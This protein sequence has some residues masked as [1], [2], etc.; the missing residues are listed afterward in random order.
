MHRRLFMVLLCLLAAV[1]AACTATADDVQPIIKLRSLP[2]ATVA[3]EPMASVRGVVTWRQGPNFIMQDGAAAIFINLYES[4]RRGLT[5][6]RVPAPTVIPGAKLEVAGRLAAGGFAPILLPTEIRVL[7][8]AAM[9]DPHRTTPRRFFSGADDCLLVEVKGIVRAVQE[10]TAALELSMAVDGQRF[11]VHVDKEAVPGRYGNL[12]DAEVQVAG[13]ALARFNTRGELTMPSLAVGMGGWI[14][15]VAP[16]RQ[17]PF[18]SPVVPLRH[19]AGYRAE[20]RDGHMVRIQGTVNHAVPAMELFLQDGATGV[21]VATASPEVFTPG[22]RVEAAGFIETS[23]RVASLSHA[24]VRRIASGTPPRP[25]AITP[26]EIRAKNLFAA[27]AFTMAEPGDY[28]GCLVTFPATLLEKQATHRGGTLIL[29]AGKSTVVATL[30]VADEQR[31]RGLMPGSELELT[32]IAHTDWEP[33]ADAWDWVA[34]VSEQIRLVVRSADDVRVLKAPSWWTP[35]RLALLAGGLAAVAVGAILW[36]VLLRQQ[37]TRLARQIAEQIRLRRDA[38]VEFEATLRERNRLAVNLH[39]TVLQ[40]VTGIGYQVAACKDDEGRPSVDI[41]RHF[42]LVERMVTHAVRQLRGTV[43]ALKA[44]APSGRPFPAALGDLA[45][46]L[47]E[48]RDAVIDVAVDPQ[49]PAIDKLVAGNLL[50][51][52]Q[53]SLLNALRHADASAIAVRVGPAA[54]LAADGPPAVELTVRDDGQGFDPAARPDARQGHFGIEGMCERVERLGGSMRIESQV[55]RGTTVVV[56]VPAAVASP[57][58]RTGR[59]PA[60]ADSISR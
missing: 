26:D 29:A 25:M 10:S 9:P 50:L 37:A 60:E 34:S 31:L 32:G 1:A 56:R 22:D 57:D 2:P 48:E 35:R 59:D 44:A 15:V 21:R 39:D 49:T 5:P 36:V 4:R 3:K 14:T 33:T 55:G 41:E 45:A 17:P 20:P 46:R 51:I 43:W 38:A 40:T 12:V 47:G 6:L 27:Q 18:E 24:V 11:L 52:A 16:P 19:L 54:L 30:S 8:T 23:G 28:E 7:G 42:G 13:V 58:N 53:E